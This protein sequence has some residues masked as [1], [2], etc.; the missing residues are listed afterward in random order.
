MD[1]QPKKPTLKI[2]LAWL[3]VSA[4]LVWGVTQTLLKALALFD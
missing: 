4:P 2:V 1:T 3:L